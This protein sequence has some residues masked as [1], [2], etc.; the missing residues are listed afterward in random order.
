MDLKIHAYLL[1]SYFITIQIFPQIAA[2]EIMHLVVVA[3]SNH[4]WPYFS[5]KKH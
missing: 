2:V 3:S 1:Q 5:E 4:K